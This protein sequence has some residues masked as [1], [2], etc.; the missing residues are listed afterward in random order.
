[1]PLFLMLISTHQ[2]QLFAASENME[3][4]SD[5]STESS[6]QNHKK[7]ARLNRRLK[8]YKSNKRWFQQLLFLNNLKD[9]KTRQRLYICRTNI[10]TDWKDTNDNSFFRKC[11]S[12]SSLDDPHT[13]AFSLLGASGESRWAVSFYR[14]WWKP[15]MKNVAKIFGSVHKIFTLLQSVSTKGLILAEFWTLLCRIKKCLDSLALFLVIIWSLCELN[16]QNTLIKEKILEL[17]FRSSFPFSL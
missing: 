4:D 3:E 13:S 7:A 1:M 8:K 2:I 6:I 10:S 17:W 16:I 14:F 5:S 15:M 12:Q 11:R 9:V